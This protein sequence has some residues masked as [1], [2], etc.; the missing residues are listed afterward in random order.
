MVS[1]KQVLAADVD[2]MRT[3]IHVELFC[4]FV[5]PPNDIAGEEYIA[6]EESET[7]DIDL[8]AE[9][10][11]RADAEITVVELVMNVVNYSCAK[12]PVPL[13][14]PGVIEPA[15]FDSAGNS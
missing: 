7:I 12:R 5:P 1:P 9:L 6:V 11:Q 15:R 8:G 13:E 14:N 4:N 3:E 2:Y 10:L